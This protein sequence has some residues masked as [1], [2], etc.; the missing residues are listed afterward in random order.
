VLL[1]AFGVRFH[2]LDAQ[3]LWNDEGN[4]LRLAQRNAGDLIDA[5]G[6]D[7]HPPGYY[8]LLKAWIGAAGTSEFGLRALS[9]FAGV[10]TV[11]VTVALGRALFGKTAGLTAGLV[12]A[13]NAFAV[14]YSQ[15]TRMYALLGLLSAASMW[16]FVVWLN[17]P[18][19]PVNR[20]K[21]ALLL[22]VINAVGL[23]T[24]YSFP[25][26]MLAQGVVFGMWVAWQMWQAR[27]APPPAPLPV[28]GEGESGQTSSPSP[29]AGR[30]LGRDFLTYIALNVLTLLL[31]LP[32]LP[33]AWDQIT[34]WPR[35]GESIAWGEQARTVLT[36]IM[37]GN[38]SAP[39]L[40]P[41][42]VIPGLLVLAALWGMQ[43]RVLLPLIWAGIVIGA[44]FVSGAYR[45]AN[46]KFLL[47]AQI[48]VALLIGQGAARLWRT[49]R[50]VRIVGIQLLVVVLLWQISLLH[51][52]YTDPD[53]ARDDYRA[54]AATIQANEQPG[55]AI[56]LDA[57]NQAEVFSYYYDGSA[58]VYELPRGL[59]GDDAVTRADVE[60]V[61]ALHRRIFV[62][63]WGEAERDP[64]RIVQATLDAGA[65]PVTSE[66]VGDVRIALYVVLDD[67][68]DAPTVTTTARF[69]DS[70]T[71]TG[72]AL[73]AGSLIPGDVL[74]VILFWRTD[75]PLDARYAVTVQLLAPD[76]SLVSQHD[77]EPGNNRALTSTW[78]PGEIVI[79]PHGVIAPPGLAPGQYTIIVGLYDINAPLDR[80]PVRVDGAPVG[81]V[82]TLPPLIVS[83]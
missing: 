83:E 1:I 12:V 59:G 42:L 25:F 55:D 8:L 5:A 75:A 30:D 4:S 40:W 73:S 35:T 43:R 15:E 28:H 47:P 39:A 81:D 9:A 32:W 82:F 68:P 77:A 49:F 57:P 62:L 52:L 36:W 37:Y 7:I 24:Q 17:Q 56:I 23:Y 44:L 13:L 20:W 3:S 65:Y 63:F 19:S 60:T 41:T 54:M 72:Y 58:P 50:D 6:R 18:H 22:A 45:E 79:D 53:Y 38:T 29:R 34:N 61:I 71:L 80:L 27:L 11:A 31:F 78:T 51:A 46:L 33:T 14:Y 76:G 66:W 10:L 21:W 16:V 26:T 48:A 74:G 64:N 2:D 70:I 69:G 67:P